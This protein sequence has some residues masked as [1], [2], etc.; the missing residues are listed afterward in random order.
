M[1]QTDNEI[2]EKIRGGEKHQ[3]SLIMAR[4]SD[5]AYSLSLRILGNAEDAEE[6]LQDAFIRAYNSLAKFEG[7]AKFSTWFYRIVY[8]A[9]ITKLNQRGT[10]LDRIEY[11]DDRQYSDVEVFD[12]GLSEMTY[13]TRDMIAFI[14]KVIAELPKKYAAILTLFYLEDMTHEEIC[15]VLQIP[16]GTVKVHLH[17]AR[18]LLKEQL[19]KEFQ[20]I[21][22]PA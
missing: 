1:A 3:Y 14:K 18:A 13:E 6:A 2:I 5:K 7:R 8:N 21:K 10:D 9:C 4:Y 15:D 20:T 19:S 11:D 22:I 17:R 16:L 12:S